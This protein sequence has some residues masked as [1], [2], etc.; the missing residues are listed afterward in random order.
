[1][2]GQNHIKFT[3]LCMDRVC[4]GK[5]IPWPNYSAANEKKTFNLRKSL[6]LRFA[7]LRVLVSTDK[8]KTVD[9]SNGRC[10]ESLLCSL[11]LSKIT[12]L[13]SNAVCCKF[14]HVVL[15]QMALSFQNLSQFDE[16][17]SW[18][19]H[20][21]ISKRFVPLAEQIRILSSALCRCSLTVCS[22]CC[23][24]IS[25]YRVTKTGYISIRAETNYIDF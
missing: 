13:V 22:R 12:P 18:Q 19:F 5:C 11:S 8:W 15:V 25:P 24:R 21:E 23:I 10:I 16:I 7:S 4:N 2:H 17:C 20:F 6:R 14:Y 9:C 3:C 1:M